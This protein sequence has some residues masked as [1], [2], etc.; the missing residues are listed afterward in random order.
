MSD[1]EAYLAE[2]ERLHVNGRYSQA[3]Y[4]YTQAIGL[5]P[6]ES[7]G[8]ELRAVAHYDQKRYQAALSDFNEVIRLNPFNDVAHWGKGKV[9][10]AMGDVSWAIHNYSRAIDLNGDEAD[11]YQDRAAA[12]RQLGRYREADQDEAMAM[13][14]ADC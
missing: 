11:Y 7:I 8:Y 10:A 2:G 9:F 13:T 1:F 4:H 6:K 14:F 12:L 3:I 5:K